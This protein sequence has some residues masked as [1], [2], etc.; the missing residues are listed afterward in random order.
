MW[1]REL[2][3][4]DEN[5]FLQ[6]EYKYCSTGATGILQLY[7]VLHRQYWSIAQWK[8][9]TIRVNVCEQDALC[10]TVILCHITR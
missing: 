5:V 6:M 2:D 9:A 8:N 7:G 1:G 3:F 10:C 4:R